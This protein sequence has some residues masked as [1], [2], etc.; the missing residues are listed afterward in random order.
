MS[1][2]L[3]S[4]NGN[5]SST[6]TAPATTAVVLSQADVVVIVVY[7]LIFV[8]GLIG[9]ILVIRYFGFYLKRGSTYNIYLIHLAIADLISSTVT[10]IQSVYAVFSGNIWHLGPISCTIVSIIGPLTVNVSA[11]VLGSIAFERYRGIV[12][13]FKPRW[14]K[15]R[16]HLM[17]GIIWFLS[18]ISQIPY[19]DALEM[20]DRMCWPNYQNPFYE[21]G[22][23]CVTLVLQSVMPIAFMTFTVTRIMHTLRNRLKLPSSIRSSASS[24]PQSRNASVRAK[25]KTRK[26]NIVAE[27][28]QDDANIEKTPFLKESREAESPMTSRQSSVSMVRKKECILSKINEREKSSDFTPVNKLLRESQ[29]RSFSLPVLQ[30]NTIEEGGR[31]NTD[32]LGI[33]SSPLCKTNSALKCMNEK[34]EGEISEDSHVLK[35][36]NILTQASKTNGLTKSHRKYSISMNTGLAMYSQKVT[37]ESETVTATRE[38][39]KKAKKTSNTYRRLR[40]LLSMEHRRQKCNNKRQRDRMSMLIVTF[41]VFVV[42]SLPY[43]IFYVT[44]IILI[45]LMERHELL[46]AIIE[47]NLWLSTLVLANSIMNCYIYAGMNI[48]FRNYC[49]SFFRTSSNPK[50]ADVFTSSQK[51]FFRK[52]FR[53]TKDVNRE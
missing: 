19:M 1:S 49:C 46:P 40:S 30:E 14:T 2:N 45:D 26:K 43:N 51:S 11:W 44:A 8:F 18:L 33:D 17:V 27:E 13:P 16:I 4:H 48:G 50:N 24:Q 47:V 34:A 15:F 53:Y 39:E 41:S 38:V 25:N 10:P 23:A 37:R 7:V 5:G 32:N 9:N 6:T 31:A 12:K 22:V 20:T 36:N 42:C 28:F 21:L 52:S 29:K 35:G 3:T